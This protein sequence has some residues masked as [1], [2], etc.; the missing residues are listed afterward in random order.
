MLCF[1]PAFPVVREVLKSREAVCTPL[2]INALPGPSL[3]Q[4]LVH[5]CCPSLGFRQEDI[6]C[7]RDLEGGWGS[8]LQQHGRTWGDGSGEKAW[9]LGG[10]TESE[11]AR[12]GSPGPGEAGAGVGPPVLELGTAFLFPEQIRRLSSTPSAAS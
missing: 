8:R 11:R 3:W 10:D 4:A 5:L 6:C 9:G 2:I 7:Q 12:G 1:L